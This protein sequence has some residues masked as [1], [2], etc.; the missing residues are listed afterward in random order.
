MQRVSLP[1][2][3]VQTLAFSFE[4]RWYPPDSAILFR[5]Q[6]IIDTFLAQR[7]ELKH[8]QDL[9]SE[10]GKIRHGNFWGMDFSKNEVDFDL[11]T[12]VDNRLRSHK[13]LNWDTDIHVSDFLVLNQFLNSSFY[14]SPF[15][16]IQF[17]DFRTKALT[18]HN[19]LLVSANISHKIIIA[20]Y[21]IGFLWRTKEHVALFAY[22]AAKE[23]W[24]FWIDLHVVCDQFFSN[25]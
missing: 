2:Q 9:I 25:K 18:C 8:I 1:S 15:I 21:I 6:R 3:Q 11:S 24:V 22:N 12:V 13:F 23:R 5:M 4:L 20:S 17:Q 14:W 10:H 16:F 19:G 7:H